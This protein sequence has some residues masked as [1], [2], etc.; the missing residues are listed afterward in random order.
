MK[1]GLK[2]W[3]TNTGSYLCEAVRL[4]TNKVFDYLELYY[5]PESIGSAH[6][7]K[8][9]GIP[10]IVHAPHSAHDVNLAASDHEVRNR[11]IYD[12]VSAFSD[13]LE[14]SII[15]AH[16]GFFGELSEVV[17]QLN[18]IGDKRIIVENKPYLPV[19][20]T[21]RRL[22]GSTPEEIRMILDG[23]GLGF[24]FDVGHAV[25][26]ANVHGAKW[27]E[28]F[29][30]FME[31]KPKMFHLSDIDINSVRDQHLH[32]GKGSLPIKEILDTIPDASKISI[33]TK[34]DS[35]VN[36]VDF[37]EDVRCLKSF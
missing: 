5:V 20:D 9:T 28:Y 37:E 26:S 22:V 25:A 6:E 4:Y 13:R 3:S 18:I 17:R 14:A 11:K 23:T 29:A 33:E 15:I 30:S 21:P 8:A 19:D 16:S 1:I 7:W 27:R 24:C 34:K 10:C 32:F 36:L 31:L 2:L 35:R 12:E